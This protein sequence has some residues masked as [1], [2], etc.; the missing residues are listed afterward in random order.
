MRSGEVQRPFPSDKFFAILMN[1]TSD[2]EYELVKLVWDYLIQIT[3][4]RLEYNL[5][6][7]NNW[8]FNL[9]A[10]GFLSRSRKPST[11][12]SNWIKRLTPFVKFSLQVSCRFSLALESRAY[13]ISYNK[14]F[15]RSN[16][17]MLS[18]K[19]NSDEKL[20]YNLIVVVCPFPLICHMSR[21]PYMSLPTKRCKFSTT[22]WCRRLTSDAGTYVFILQRAGFIPRFYFRHA[23]YVT[24]SGGRASGRSRDNHR[25]NSWIVTSLYSNSSC[26]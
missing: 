25:Q 9:I 18:L 1:F 24:P 23:R 7:E 5:Y 13:N 14:Y 17:C 22:L 3:V 2:G 11:G 20:H 26:V 12:Q 4:W 21:W 8:Q 6:C 10:H 19:D 16:T 15:I